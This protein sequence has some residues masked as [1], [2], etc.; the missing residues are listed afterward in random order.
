LAIVDGGSDGGSDASL[1]RDA[2]SDTSNAPAYFSLPLIPAGTL[3]E[4]RSY[5]AVAT[6]CAHAVS[7]PDG[8]GADARALDAGDADAEA[9]T[10]TVVDTGACGTGFGPTTLGL[11][12][13]RLSRRTNPS[14]LGFQTVNASN[15]ASP[16]SLVV[17]QATTAASVYIADTVAFGQ[18]TPRAQPTFVSKANLGVI[19]RA[20]LLRVSPSAGGPSFPDFQTDLATILLTN[21]VAEADLAEATNFTF[22]L[23]G[24]RPGRSSDAGEPPFRIGLVENAPKRGDAD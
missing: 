15:A 22:V 24:A 18:I 19:A 7:L 20:A 2:D 13:V 8:G 3:G 6:G 17:E 5:L 12:L 23:L 1:Q 21:Q 16:A 14:K 11:S 9:G 10:D 4:A